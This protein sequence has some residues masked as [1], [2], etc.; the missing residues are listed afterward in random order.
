MNRES[1]RPYAMLIIVTAI[2]STNFI[3]GKS[4]TGFPPL[5]IAAARFTVAAVIFTPYLISKKKYPT[6]RTW[7]I[8]FLMGV[9]GIF[10]FNPLVYLGL[11][12]TTSINVTLINSLSPLS[13]AIISNLWLKEELTGRKIIGLLISIFG[14]II[15]VTQGQPGRILSLKFNSGDI[16]ILLN[17]IIW[18]VYTVLVKKSAKE[19]TPIQSTALATLSGLIFLLPATFIESIWWPIPHLTWGVILLFIYLGIFPSVI[20][21]LLWNT[22]VTKVGP[23]KAGILYNLIPLFNII[24]ALPL[25]HEHLYKYQ[26]EG[27][28]IIVF[29]VAVALIKGKKLSPYEN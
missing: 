27:G 4:L 6:R 7:G 3:A 20:A 18:A 9:T 17:T 21:F 1:L 22:A 12:Y 13:V 26:A 14:I 10:L 11:H 5:F 24:L 29:G 8:V 15:V 19:F 28:I 25:L 16:I 2:W 23:T